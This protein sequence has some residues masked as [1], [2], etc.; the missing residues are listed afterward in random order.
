MILHGSLSLTIHLSSS[1][2]TSSACVLKVT[3]KVWVGARRAS[4][5]TTLVTIAQYVTALKPAARYQGVHHML[6]REETTEMP[7]MLIALWHTVETQLE[8]KYFPKF[9]NMTGLIDG[10][11]HQNI[12]ISF[13]VLKLQILLK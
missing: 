12:A 2:L 1:Q 9:I 10:F 13:D 5:K 8:A 4:L 3:K 6:S 11:K 7:L